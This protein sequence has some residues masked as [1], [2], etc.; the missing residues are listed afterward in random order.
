MLNLT[1]NTV[2]KYPNRVFRPMQI[3]TE[4]SRRRHHRHLKSNFSMECLLQ[5]KVGDIITIGIL[6]RMDHNTG[7]LSNHRCSGHPQ[8]RNNLSMAHSLMRRIG[9]CHLQLQDIRHKR[10]HTNRGIQAITVSMADRSHLH[11][12]PRG[13]LI[14]ELSNRP[15]MSRFAQTT[16][17]YK[18]LRRMHGHQIFQDQNPLLEQ[19]EDH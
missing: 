18:G 9:G 5:L 1:V 15:R 19:I 6:I 4:G 16:I 8:H 3:F 10:T 7:D 2:S 17:R 11:F 14:F 12:H 13:N